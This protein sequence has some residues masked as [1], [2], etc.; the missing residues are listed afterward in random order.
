MSRDLVKNAADVGQ[1]KRAEQILARRARRDV[2]DLREV[3][4]TLP[5][6]RLVGRWL[7]KCGIYESCTALDTRIY[8]L[9]GRRDIG[10]EL[11]GEVVQHHELYL[12]MEKERRDLVRREE[13]ENAAVHD[14]A[15]SKDEDA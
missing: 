8:V 10:L 1:L 13:R 5:G 12:Q 9:S 14:A 2:E 4:Q 11:L 7:R 15:A 6:R 3:L